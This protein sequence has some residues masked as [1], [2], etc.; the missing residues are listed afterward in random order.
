[1]IV[2]WPRSSLP[3]PLC[4]V[5]CATV[6]VVPPAAPVRLN[7]NVLVFTPLEVLN[8]LLN[9]AMMPL[10]TASDELTSLMLPPPPPTITNIAAIDLLAWAAANDHN[11]WLATRCLETLRGLCEDEATA[12][13]LV[14]AG[15]HERL[16]GWVRSGDQ[17]Y[18]D[19]VFALITRLTRFPTAKDA[20][21]NAGAAEATVVFWSKAIGAQRGT[22]LF[23]PPRALLAL[24]HNKQQFWVRSGL[25]CFAWFSA[26]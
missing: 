19:A 26:C 25:S 16:V 24:L 2:K 20:L 22:K 8:T 23:A 5:P 12:H 9:H 6:A 18:D 3:S 17:T 4:C 11:D 14:Q 13:I 1:M 10:E 21:L 15:T 7:K